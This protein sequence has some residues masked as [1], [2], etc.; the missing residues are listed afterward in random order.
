MEIGEAVA[1]QMVELEME[2]FCK[3]VKV[4]QSGS[5]VIDDIKGGKGSPDTLRQ[6]M[7]AA[8]MPEPARAGA[9]PPWDLFACDPATFPYQS[10]HLI[11]EKQLPKHAVCTW[12]TDSPKQKHAKYVLAA[13][14]KY[15]TNGAANGYFMPFASTTNEWVTTT[16]GTRRDKICCEMMRRTRMQLHQGPH[17]MRDY[18][19]EEEIE[20]AGYKKMVSDFLTRIFESFEKHVDS[21]TPCKNKASPKIEVQPLDAA[22]DQMHTASALLEAL[23]QSQRIF[24]SK[25][26]ANYFKD[27]QKNGVLMHPTV[28]FV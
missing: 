9:A 23:T 15:D 13:D 28:P 2:E 14:T 6:N 10:H 5:A 19:E 26:A 22:V 3:G 18:L 27:H 24:V 11:P 7:I 16:S 25:R 8:T 20:T 4:K 1:I 21:C 12:L 17:S